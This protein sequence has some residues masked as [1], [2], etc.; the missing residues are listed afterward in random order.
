MPDKQNLLMNEAS[1][2]S[3]YTLLRVAMPL[4][5]KWRRHLPFLLFCANPGVG[6]L[7]FGCSHIA[8]TLF[9]FCWQMNGCLPFGPDALYYIAGYCSSPVAP[10]GGVA[11]G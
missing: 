8:F 7:R 1:H 2:R 10:F 5:E 3:S 4:R 11:E 6:F 9:E